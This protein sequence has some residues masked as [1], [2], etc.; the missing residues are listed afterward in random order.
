ME[1]SIKMTHW[2]KIIFYSIVSFFLIFEMAIQVSPSVMAGFLIDDLHISAFGLGLMSGVYFYTYAGMQIP[3]GLLFD[4]YHPRLLITV[5]ILICTLGTLLF[6]VAQNIYVGSLARLL[7]GFGSAF[8]F[9]AVLIVT[10]ELFNTKYFATITGV[11]QMLAAFG[12]MTGQMPISELVTRIGWRSTLYVLCVIG[13]ILAFLVWKVLR[14]DR[15][16]L[17]HHNHSYLKSLKEIL[18]HRQTW[19]VAAYACL[20]WAPMSSFASLWGVPFLSSTY[21]LSQTEA[22]FLCSLMWLG[23]AIASPL[24]GMFSNAVRYRVIPLALSALVGAIAF[25]CVLECHASVMV[26][27]LC[28]FLAGAGCSGQALSFTLVKENNSHSVKGA[29]IAFN[30][31]AV[32]ISGA[33]FQ[34]LIGMLIDLNNPEQFKHGLYIILFAYIVAFVIVIFLIKEPNT[35][36]SLRQLIKRLFTKHPETVGESYFQH[37]RFAS[38]S[39]MK[40]TIAGVKCM[41]HSVC[42]FLFVNAASDFVRKVHRDLTLRKHQA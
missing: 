41:V 20:L 6:A 3:S 10:A 34:P 37:L 11:T 17:I 5:S 14:Y 32:V 39:G 4:R 21:Q 1:N 9:V 35:P 22:A 15:K 36:N 23:L 27:G 24:L 16:T 33:L 42:P 31:M 28:L 18:S 13:I 12:A 29:A 7:M 30:N 2:K 38:R 19:S 40:M 26:L 8:A 25:F